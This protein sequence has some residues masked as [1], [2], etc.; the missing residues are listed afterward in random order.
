[1]KIDNIYQTNSISAFIMQEK[2]RNLSENY[3]LKIK[4]T[5]NKTAK[6]DPDYKVFGAKKHKYILN[7]I[8]SLNQVRQF[9]Q[10]YQIT[11]PEEYVYFLTQ[12]GNGG[13]GP[14]YGI[15][16]L[17]TVE[18]KNY[19]LNKSVQNL[20]FIDNKLT[21]E[22][23]KKKTQI[24]DDSDC[25]DEIYDEIEAQVAAG[26]LE[27]GTQGCT[28]GNI[29]MYKGSETGKIVYFDWD[30]SSESPPYLTGMTFLDWYLSFFEEI[31]AGHYV[32]SF[33]YKLLCTEEALIELFY[34]AEKL[35]E[36]QKILSSFYRFPKL[37]DQS[38]ALL[39][40]IK[41]HELDCPRLALLFKNNS[42][43]AMQVFDQLLEGQNRNAAVMTATYM[44]NKYKNRYY[45][46]MLE[47]L[48]GEN[49]ID[50]E[51][52]L[53]F[54]KECSC[55]KA[56][57]IA[58]F[59][60]TLSD[61]KTIRTTI[62]YMGKCDDVLDCIDQFITWMQFNYHSVVFD[63]LYIMKQTKSKDKRLLETYEWMKTKFQEDQH[64]YTLLSV[65]D[66][67]EDIN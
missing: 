28:Y 26:G 17:E 49:N 27:I 66:I 5:I 59:A 58:G 51:S 7:P 38:I 15:Y 55:K 8:I 22:L 47:I 43:K 32:T 11:L 40:N 1:M 6:I 67:K 48:Y 16:S 46:R 29:L 19:C 61:I 63:A 35:E 3:T 21:P 23:W 44:P 4:K 10:K 12:I 31:A 9:E 60:R 65:E 34:R 24:L 57:D 25:S 53:Y 64:I 13:A 30:I 56:T 37:S 14:Y 18:Q 41:D 39:I 50:K 33:G 42:E 54:L 36:K 52:I 2:I 45:N 20:V 62:D